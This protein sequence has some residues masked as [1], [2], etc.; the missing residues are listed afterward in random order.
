MKIIKTLF[1]AIL[2]IGLTSC[3]QKVSKDEAEFDSLLVEVFAVH[4]EMMPEMAKI[5]ELRQ[6]LEEKALEEPMDSIAYKEAMDE[7]T[8]AH[9]GMMDWMKDFG[10]VFPYKENRLEGMSEEQVKESIS[11][12]KEQK[13]TVDAMKLKMVESMENAKAVLEN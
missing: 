6:Q 7:L 5:S 8:A 11:L 13:V 9:D 12:M 1:V 2:A 10:E 3:E 4:D